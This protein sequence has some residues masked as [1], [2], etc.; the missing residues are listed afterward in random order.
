[1]KLAA[2]AAVDDK[3]KMR[4]QIH[5]RKICNDTLNNGLVA[6]FNQGLGERVFAVGKNRFLPAIGISILTMILGLQTDNIL[7]DI[8]VGH[9]IDIVHLHHQGAAGHSRLNAPFVVFHN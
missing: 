8:V 7:H 1:V 4:I 9:V 2:I 5:L 6:D 3:N